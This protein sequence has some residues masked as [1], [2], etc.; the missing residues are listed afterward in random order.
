MT[1]GDC[2]VFQWDSATSQRHPENVELSTPVTSIGLVGWSQ[3]HGQTSCQRLAL[4]RCSFH[5]T[6]IQLHLGH[7]TPRTV[8]GGV[9]RGVSVGW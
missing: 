1:F 4:T 6:T 9:T 8:C 7:G 3:A 2:I 5:Q